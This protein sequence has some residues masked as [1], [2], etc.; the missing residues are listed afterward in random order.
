MCFIRSESSSRRLNRLVRVIIIL[1]IIIEVNWLIGYFEL[2]KK[3]L[4]NCLMKGYQKQV[5]A[6]GIEQ[7]IENQLKISELIRV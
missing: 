3:G 1:L 6:V 4:L 5:L 7:I 2:K